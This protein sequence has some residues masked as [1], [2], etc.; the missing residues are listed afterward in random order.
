MWGG[1]EGGREGGRGGGNGNF[2]LRLIKVVGKTKKNENPRQNK[3]TTPLSYH[4]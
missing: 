1:R 4:G 3:K 2:F